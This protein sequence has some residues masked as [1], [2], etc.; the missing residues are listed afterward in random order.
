MLKDC[1][2]GFIGAGAMAESILAG[3]LA[4]EEVN[5]DQIALVNR[6]HR[7]RLQ[8]LID[9]Y[10]LQAAK[11]TADHV[12]QADIV[13][14][15]VKPKDVLATLST[16]KSHLSSRQLIISVVA[17]IT[18]EIIERAIGN[19]AAVIRAMPNT[20]CAVGLSATALCGGSHVSEEQ[21]RLAERIFMSIGSVIRVDEQAMD[22]VTGLSGS[23]PAYV[24]YMVE[25]L[26]AAGVRAGLSAET[27]RQLTVQTLLGAAHMLAETGKE[28][29]ELR[30]E[31][32][33]PGGT[34]M[35]GLE[36]LDRWKV[37]EAIERAVLRAKERSMEMG[38]LLHRD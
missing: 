33:S 1:M 13:I 38:A 11:Q 2:I 14:L 20:S 25:A 16:W 15:A 31:V 23:G 3:L 21:I 6:N 32:T 10:H 22:A 30:D 19:G 4:K 24:Y 5:S 9:R 18:T 26:Q 34:T 35:A 7:L 29:K 28:A 17:G 12:A 37:S 8:E 27:A 36:M